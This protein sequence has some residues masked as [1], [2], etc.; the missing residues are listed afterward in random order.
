MFTLKAPK[1]ANKAKRIVGRGRSTGKGKTAG[2][3]HKGQNSRSGGGVRLGFEG[4]QMPLFRRVSKRGFSN[5]PFKKV[6]VVINVAKLE[7]TF[8]DGENV[9]L[10]SLIAKGLIKKSEKLVKILG[11]GDISKK[12][13]VSDV[14]VSGIAKEKVEKA[15][16][17]IVEKA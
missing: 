13:T 3:G 11:D 14:K 15:G 6:Y 16:G 7:E 17:S 1:G 2:R 5:Y 10:D 9:N 4:G 8:S 12:I